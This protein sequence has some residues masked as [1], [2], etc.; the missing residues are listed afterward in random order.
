VS[1]LPWIH[2]VRLTHRTLVSFCLGEP[3]CEVVASALEFLGVSERLIKVQHISGD[4]GAAAVKEL[5]RPGEGNPAAMVP[6]SNMRYSSLTPDPPHSLTSGAG[7]QLVLAGADRDSAQE[8]PPRLPANA[9][10]GP[11]NSAVAQ[12]Y[13][14]GMP[15]LNNTAPPNTPLSFEMLDNTM[16]QAHKRGYDA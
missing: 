14:C 1:E 8:T 9:S 15:Q 3:A 13:R 4:T 12:A 16:A 6:D 10:S 2:G 11:L 5:G 7:V